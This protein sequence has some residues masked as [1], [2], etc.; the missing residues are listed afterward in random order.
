MVALLYLALVTE[1]VSAPPV[2][3]NRSATLTV[4][5]VAAAA[6]ADAEKTLIPPDRSL[7]GRRAATAREAAGVDMYVEA[8]VEPKTAAGLVEL[9]RAVRAAA[10]EVL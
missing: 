1:Y 5:A 8:N 2:E 4:G 6:M 10:V 9:L 7:G 3:E